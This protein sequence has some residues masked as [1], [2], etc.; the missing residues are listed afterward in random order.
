MPYDAA[1]TLSRVIYITNPTNKTGTV[2]LEVG[3][4]GFKCPVVNTGVVA[5]SLGVTK[6]TGAVDSAV[7]S[8]MGANFE[9][10]VWVLLAADFLKG[11]AAQAYSA[12]ARGG[13]T[14]IVVNTSNA[15]NGQ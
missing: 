7:A 1:G 11:E 13:N 14:Y 10:K 4:T 9:G 2:S 3:A 5:A 6:L 12:Y 8:C 15:T